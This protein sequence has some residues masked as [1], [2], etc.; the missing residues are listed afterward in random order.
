MLSWILSCK[1]VQPSPTSACVPYTPRMSRSRCTSCE[2]TQEGRTSGVCHRVKMR[3]RWFWLSE[4]CFS[5]IKLKYFCAII[6]IQKAFRPHFLMD[7]FGHLR[8]SSYICPAVSHFPWIWHMAFGTIK[9]LSSV[10]SDGHE[11]RNFNHPKTDSNETSAQCVQQAY[12]RVCHHHTYWRG[13]SRC[14][15]LGGR[16]CEGP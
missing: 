2:R 11:L 7:L 12:Q 15:S 4:R 13:L 9:T 10:C 6:H 16:Q 8:E 3:V 5:M 1:V 14:L